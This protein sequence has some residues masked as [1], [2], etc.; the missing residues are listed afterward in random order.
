MRVES[1]TQET[2]VPGRLVG[3]SYYWLDESARWNWLHLRPAS[4]ILGRDLNRSTLNDLISR[5]RNN[6]KMGTYNRT[7]HWTRDISKRTDLWNFI[8]LARISGKWE[9][10]DAKR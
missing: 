4:I 2:K 1:W 5:S 8:L 3:H 6:N 10:H 7:F 9:S